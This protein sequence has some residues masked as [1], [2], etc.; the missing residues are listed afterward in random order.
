MEKEILG[1]EDDV[2]VEIPNFIP[3]WTM[4]YCNFQSWIAIFL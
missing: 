1:T 4:K 3:F 2:C